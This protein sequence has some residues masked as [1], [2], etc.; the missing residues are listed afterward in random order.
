MHEGV[1]PKFPEPNLPII[2]CHIE[3]SQLVAAQELMLEYLQVGAIQKMD[4][5]GTKYLIPW[6]VLS[7]PECYHQK[8]QRNTNSRALNGFFPLLP[9]DQ[10]MGKTSP[11]YARGCGRQKWI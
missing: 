8:H 3:Q 9:S 11:I 7:K 6:F 10:I 1:N 5:L 4:L 2:E